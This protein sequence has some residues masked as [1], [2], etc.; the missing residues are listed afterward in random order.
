MVGDQELLPIGS[1]VTM[2]LFLTATRFRPPAQKLRSRVGAEK[3]SIRGY[4]GEEYAMTKTLGGLKQELFQ[5]RSTTRC[6]P[7]LASISM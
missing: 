4:F 6:L 3:Q 1:D 2:G 5:V 7:R